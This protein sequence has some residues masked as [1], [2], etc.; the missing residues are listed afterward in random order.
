MNIFAFNLLEVVGSRIPAEAKKI[1]NPIFLILLAIA[2]IA[3]IILILAQ[4]S[5]GGN[6][7]ALSGGN[8]ADSFYGKNK[9]TLKDR[10]IKIA[11]I[12]LGVFIMVMSI[13]FFI[14]NKL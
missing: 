7:N 12:V 3:I 1:I 4:K 5:S 14:L 2:A 10:K 8:D 11:T 9:K 6:I 13:L